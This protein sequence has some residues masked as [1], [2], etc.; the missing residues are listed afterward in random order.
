MNRYIAIMLLTLLTALPA[1]AQQRITGQVVDAETGDTVPFASLKYRGRKLSAVSDHAGRFS[2]ERHDGWT[3]VFSSVGYKSERVAIEADTKTPF[4][5][6]LEPEKQQLDEVTVKSKKHRYS[7]RDN[8]AVELMRRVIAA[9]KR[10]DISNHDYY[11]Y[12]NYQKITMAANDIKPEDLEEGIFKISPWMTAQVEVCSLNNKLTLPFSVDETVTRH[13]YRRSPRT[14]KDI[15]IG[16]RS[17]GVNHVL[18]T[19][20][21]LNTVLKDA[22]T[23]IDIYDDQ[24]RLLRHFF[25]SP[26]GKD[27]ISFYRFYIVDTV[28]VDDDLCYHLEFLPN[29]QQDFGFRGELYVLAD[30]T[31]H[32]RQCNMMLP[33]ASDVNFVDN[34]W[35]KQVYTRLDSGDWVLTDDDMVVEMS[36]Y[37]AHPQALVTR[38]TRRTD[39]SFDEISRKLFRGKAMVYTEPDALMRDTAFWQQHRK[40]ELTRGENR[41]GDFLKAMRQAKGYKLI[42]AGFKLLVENYVETGGEKHPSKVDIGPINT[43]VSSNFIDGL[44]FRASAQTTANLFPHL[45]LKGYYAHGFKNDKNYYSATA[46]YS[47]NKK[48]YAYSEFPCRNLTFETTYD[49]YG[50]SDKFLTHDKDNVYTSL[51]WTDADKMMFYN[52]Q[53]LTFEYETDYNL[54][55]K[56]SVQTEKNVACGTLQFVTLD[57]VYPG[58]LTS[59]SNMNNGS[60]HTADFKVTLRYAPGEKY[61]NTKQRRV[62]VNQDAPVYTLTHT[63][64]MKGFL[65]SD[66]NYNLTE[67]SVYKRFWLNS[68]GKLEATLSAGIQWNKVPFPL[69]MMPNNNLSYI[70]EPN[71][72]LLISDMEFLHDRYVACDLAWDLKGKLLNRVPLLRKLKLREFLGFRAIVAD[73]S[74]KNN[75]TL[76]RNAGDSRLMY[77]PGT[78]SI[79]SPDKPYA[80]VSI[81]IHNIF[82]ILQVQYVRRLNYNDIPTATKN[83]I[84]F[85]FNFTF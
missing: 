58:E 63:T 59:A 32:V 11:E 69:L 78:T 82:K 18:Q 56:V 4:T 26:I 31:L 74:D 23:D 48:K 68:W 21:M 7:R 15:I 71:S 52:R 24:I 45:F 34:L 76:E 47:F 83:G 46:V 1:V 55:F 8:P 16:Q 50:P 85:L 72:F 70:A 61:M 10:T 62:T 14:E 35:I 64:G 80:E 42:L 66:Y 17:E 25:T 79:M 67:L 57:D 19:G 65:G 12:Y 9:K 2:I 36:L 38:T 73:L 33:K 29:N 20:E 84:R 43:I 44:R 13:V 60:I 51:K 81:G 53:R 30:T 41:M 77:F 37:N 75:P 40:A 49:V 27:A 54:S 5:V 22:F 28:K 6:R 3:L 39:Y